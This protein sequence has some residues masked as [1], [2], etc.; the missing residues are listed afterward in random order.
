MIRTG[1]LGHPVGHSRS[2]DIHA[3]GFASAGVDGRYE[4]LDV[5][6]ADLNAAIHR[7]RDAGWRGVN[8]TIPHKVAGFGLCDRLEPAARV[9]GAVNTLTFE[10]DGAIVGANTDVDGLLGSLRRLCGFEPAGRTALVLGA[11]GAARGVVAALH[12]AG[13]S[14]VT[15]AARRLAA[16]EALAHALGADARPCTRR[17]LADLCPAAV[18]NATSAGMGC[19]PGTDAWDRATAF[20]EALPLPAWGAP[21]CLDLVYAPPRTPF[22]A[23]G[24]AA[25]CPAFC[26]LDMLARQA[27]IAFERW[28]G[29][30]ADGVLP[31][32]MRALEP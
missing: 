26:G 7:L 32:M 2:P 6:P 11:G 23:L 3:A 4:A 8:L 22:L 29:V 27:A 28:T 5:P 25:G 20:F 14:R 12:W 19:R 21:V 17:D 15:V 1:L 24:E 31:A 9:V 30:P 10:S 16:S 13:A 18:I